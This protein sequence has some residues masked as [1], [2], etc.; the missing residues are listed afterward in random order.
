MYK[1]LSGSKGRCCL[2]AQV[3][4]GTDSG[5]GPVVGLCKHDNEP[6]GFSKAG[7]IFIT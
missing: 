5:Q 4:M 3:W 1:N 7:N 2:E 6:S